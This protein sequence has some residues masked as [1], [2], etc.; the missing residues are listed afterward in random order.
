MKKHDVYI[1]LCDNGVVPE[2]KSLLSSGADLFATKDI[3]IRP[4]ETA[5]MPTG[6]KLAI[7]DTLEFQI[8][9]RSGLSAK[10][11]LR[12]AN[13]PGTGDSDY[14]DEVGVIIE[15]T[16]NISCLPYEIAANIEVLKDLH[17]NY[18]KIRLSDYLLSQGHDL[19]SFTSEKTIND[20]VLNEYI[21]LDEYDNP[22]G[23]IYIYKGNRIAQLILSQT[24]QANFIVC[25]D[26]SKHKETNRG[27]GFGHTG[28]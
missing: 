16:Y 7:P 24:Y 10:T 2:Y 26:V 28:I 22:Y 27:G 25:D 4:G 17:Y 8:R 1:E 18:K 12:I 20:N 14:L 19:S 3:I 23:T 11:S 5:I 13:S 21:Y 6:I 15:N 9:P